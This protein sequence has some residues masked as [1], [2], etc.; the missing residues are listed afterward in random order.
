[1]KAAGGLACHWAGDATRKAVE[2]PSTTGAGRVIGAYHAACRWSK[3]IIAYAISGVGGLEQFS[4]RAKTLQQ[5]MSITF[6]DGTFP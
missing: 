2:Y 6:P 4:N 1:L 3:E 5:Q